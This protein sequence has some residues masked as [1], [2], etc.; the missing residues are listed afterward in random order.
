MEIAAVTG[1]LDNATIRVAM[2]LRV[3]NVNGY[4]LLTGQG[5][6]SVKLPLPSWAV[7]LYHKRLETPF[8]SFDA[9]CVP[10]NDF[11]VC[12]RFIFTFSCFVCAVATLF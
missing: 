4:I 3:Y 11:S 12:L 5:T 10:G 8:S 7:P 6:T 9:S 2:N 1:G